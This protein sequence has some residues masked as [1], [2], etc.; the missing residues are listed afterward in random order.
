[1]A[2][3][4]LLLLLSCEQV[5]GA[6][7]HRVYG[8][9]EGAAQPHHG[10]AGGAVVLIQTGLPP[11]SLLCFCFC[12]CPASRWEVLLSI[13]C[14]EL[15]ACRSAVLLLLLLSCKQVG[16]AAEHRVY[17]AGESAAQPHHGP[18]GGAVVLIQ[19]SWLRTRCCAA[20]SAA[21]LQA[22]GSCC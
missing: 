17:G 8:A 1:M 4:P 11:H 5:G 21:V 22:G 3:L 9:G 10:P 15:S 14:T 16:A 18:A 20:A 13:V 2:V 12:C 19:T 7:E 6:A